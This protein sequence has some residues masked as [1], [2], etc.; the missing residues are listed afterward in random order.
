M[1]VPPGGGGGPA[2]LGRGPAGA[3]GGAAGAGAAVPAP[4]LICWPGRMI[5]RMLSPFQPNTS[6]SLMPWRAAIAL[7]VSP[8]FTV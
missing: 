5:E 2:A 4:I 7:R 1:R 3:G 8:G 6:E